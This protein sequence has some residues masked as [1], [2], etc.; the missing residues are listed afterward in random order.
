MEII[1]IIGVGLLTL[2]ISILLK[3]VKKE[4]SIY[5]V[6]IGTSI[7]L[8]LSMDILKEIINFIEG[9]TKN[10]NGEFI[11]ILLKMTG[12][13]ILTEYAVS[14]CKDSGESAIA[15]KIDLGG[16]IILISL[17]LSLL[18]GFWYLDL[19]IVISLSIPVISSTLE[20]LTQ[21]L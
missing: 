11:K 2:I 7:I 16:K 17:S 13:A 1:K 9:L 21:L 19:V 6:I 12:I 15:T 4:F 8:F 5:A 10:V 18:I 3:D 14:L 20:T